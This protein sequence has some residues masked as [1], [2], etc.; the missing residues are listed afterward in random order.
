MAIYRQASAPT[1]D[2]GGLWFNSSESDRPYYGTGGSWVPLGGST[3]FDG[4]T[5]TGT[6][7]STD[8]L[9]L[10]RSP[11]GYNAT[12]A[13]LFANAPANISNGL[14]VS[15]GDVS[16][17]LGGL[18]TGDGNAY[19]DLHGESG[20][21]YS[22][23]ILRATG[24]NGIF[25]LTQ[26]GTGSLRLNNASGAID[27]I[28]G[29]NYLLHQAVDGKSG[30]RTTSP[31][32]ILDI[33][34]GS[35][36]SIP[37]LMLTGGTKDLGIPAGATLIIGHWDSGT[38][39]WTDRILVN[40]SGHLHPGADNTANCGI[41]GYRWANIYAANG[42]IQT[43]DERDKAWRG[44]PSE[45]ELRA[46]WR[47]IDELGFYQWKDAIE[48]KGADGARL[49]FG[50]RAQRVWAI[51]AAAGL[52]NPIGED[53]RP[54][55]TPYAFLCFDEWADEFEDEVKTVR[56]TER[57]PV[58]EESPLLDAKGRRARKVKY[59][60]VTIEKQQPTG[61]KLLKR[62]AGNRFGVRPDQLLLFLIAAQAQRQ[63][64]IE[65]RLT[66]LEAQ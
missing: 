26:T 2:A 55:K 10:Y 22:A 18:R 57:V 1:Y 24:V 52:V 37:T 14:G 56:R 39:T 7:Q 64:A 51:M 45:S 54:G 20:V 25:Q 58:E 31:T 12:L 16:M 62:A 49:H 29:G 19:L 42:T 9:L 36:T 50:V 11:S 8:K 4:F 33:N 66:A 27:H 44:G 35:D 61:R 60:T 41:S 3:D 40:G 17:D 47:I 59:R 5:D 23:R 28:V 32:A 46:G 6:L 15:T 53:G 21:A 65:A 30:I 13:T 34:G 48:E 43:S 38:S 63:S